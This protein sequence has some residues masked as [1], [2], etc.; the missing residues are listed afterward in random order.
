M[1]RLS[2]GRDDSARK[3]GHRPRAPFVDGGAVVRLTLLTRSSD[4]AR[5]QGL[6]VGRALEA[7]HPGLRVDYR[8]R[9]ST[10]D[11]DGETPLAE[12]RDKGA[13]TADLSSALVAGDADIAV[14]SWKDLPIEPHPDTVVAATLPRADPRDVLL[15]PANVAARQPPDLVV[16]SSSPRRSFLL[17]EAL[18]GLLPWHVA[19]VHTA[20][21]RGNVPTRL[22]RLLEGRG[23]AL[24]VAKAALDRLLTCGVPFDAVGLEVRQALDQCRWMVLPVRDVPGAPAQGAL[25]VEVARRAQATIDI[26]RSI[27]DSVT[28]QG[29]AEERAMLAAR[30]GGCHAALG[31]VVLDRSYGR[32]T[33]L[34]GRTDAGATERIWQMDARSTLPPPASHDRIWPRP[35]ERGQV[36]RQALPARQPADTRGFWVARADALPSDWRLASD[37]VV[38]AP[39]TATWRQLAARGIWVN[40]CADG[41]GDEEMPGVEALA[42]R[43]LEWHRLTHVGATAPESFHTYTIAWTL[44]DDLPARTH[45]FWSSGGLF[46]EA[47]GRW[48]ML[49]DCWHASG[50]GRTSRTI[51]EALPDQ[52][53]ASVWLDYESWLRE[54]TR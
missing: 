18:P 26:V 9:Q 1:A 11:R 43:A 36:T 31:I 44:P 51:R 13:F 23:D 28:W 5:I 8:T 12:M 42:G 10:G 48:P 4:L 46:R 30:G 45:F 25:A 14:H 32:I 41:L 37:R 34:A 20:P 15:V 2:G 17:S 52:A 33:G 16:L 54:V 7:A 50:P 6:L 29:V 47:L 19:A 22:R 40:G 39:G 21:V 49:T 35:D 3:G 53:R 27:N 38:W 24:V